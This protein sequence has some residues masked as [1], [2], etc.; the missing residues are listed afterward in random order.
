M[1]LAQVVTAVT[2]GLF[3]KTTCF[4]L[5]HAFI[6]FARF[7]LFHRAGKNAVNG[8]GVI[9]VDRIFGR[10]LPVS[11]NDVFLRSGQNFEP[12]GRLIRHEIDERLGFAEKIFQRYHIGFQTA[13]DETLVAS[14]GTDLREVKDAAIEILAVTGFFFLHPYAGA[15]TLVGP[16]VETAGQRLGIAVLQRRDNGRTMGTGIEK[17]LETAVFLSMNENRLTPDMRGK[18]VTRGLHL[19]FM[20]QE[21]PV[22]LEDGAEFRFENILVEIDVPVDAE[23]IFLRPVIDHAV[24]PHR[25]DHSIHLFS[26][27]SAA[28]RLTAGV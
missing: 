24:H 2:H 3:G 22:R 7:A 13:E 23:N 8:T 15:V 4:G 25:V 9:A 6:A 14:D 16:S 5:H 21:N 28:E 26:P 17:T 27:Y 12:C 11:A 20:A 1:A 10:H 19:A 18:I